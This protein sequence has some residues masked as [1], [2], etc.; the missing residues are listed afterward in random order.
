MLN[1]YRNEL[2]IIIKDS[3]LSRTPFDKNFKLKQL[4][5]SRVPLGFMDIVSELSKTNI[6]LSP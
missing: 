4:Y 2:E 3:G 5:L 1:D 6:Q